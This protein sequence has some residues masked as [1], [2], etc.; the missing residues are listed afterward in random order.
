[1]PVSIFITSHSSTLFEAIVLHCSLLFRE[2]KRY[3][4][5]RLFSFLLPAYSKMFLDSTF[6]DYLINYHFFKWT[7]FKYIL[8]ETQCLPLLYKTYSLIIHH[9]GHYLTCRIIVASLLTHRTRQIAF[10]TRVFDTILPTDL[11]IW[12]LFISCGSYSLTTAPLASSTF[13]AL[14]HFGIISTT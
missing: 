3:T 8:P 13:S 9:P 10:Y 12:H 5:I 7:H 2:I 1:V 6:N 11:Q 4:T 14:I